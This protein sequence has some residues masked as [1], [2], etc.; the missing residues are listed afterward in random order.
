MPLQ[1]FLCLFAGALIAPSLAPFNLPYLALIPPGILYLCSYNKSPKQAFW[2]GWLFGAGFFGAGV[3]WVFV[4]ISEHSATPLPIAVIL[5]ALFVIGLGLLFAV[6]NALWIKCFG[7]RLLPLSFLGIWVLFEWI[8]SWLFTGFPWLY[9][10]NATLETPLQ[11][12]IPIGGVWLATAAFLIIS[13]CIAE[14]LRT[15]TIRPLLILPLPIICS[16]LLPLHWAES[17]GEAVK[18]A[19]IQPNIPQS[20]KWN[21]DYREEIFARYSQLSEKH[22]DVEIMLWPETAI[23]ALFR[24]AAPHLAEVLDTLDSNGVSLISGMPSLV[25]DSQHPK[26]Y[27]VHNSLAVL[28]T[29]SGIYHKQRL[30]PFG[31]YIPL[32]DFLRGAIDFFNLPMSSFSIPKTEQPL[33]YVGEYAL[34]P[35]ICYEIAYPELIRESAQQADFILTVSNDTWFGDSIAPAQH[36]QIAQVRALENGR[37]VIR[38]TNNGI[39]AVINHRG[40]VVNKLP[41]FE[42]GVLV[43]KVQAMSGHTPFQTY[44]SLPILLLATL[45]ITGSIGSR[46]A[47][48][49]DSYPSFR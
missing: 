44:G 30:V 43:E 37:W 31:E 12:L 24:N 14:F 36:L 10:G 34:A 15:K 19:V 18:V 40:E 28:T 35:A 9:L 32:E 41:Q 2:L 13:I 39:T 29:H 27:R 6:Q 4:S 5:T 49:Q 45:M 7:V 8:R 17:K 48:G 16:Y 1:L 23:P 42:E 22:S 38:G 46:K 3:S 47:W 25:S 33:L 26:G 21:A 11:N 20:I